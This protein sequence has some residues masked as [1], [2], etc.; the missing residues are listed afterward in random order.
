MKWD[1]LSGAIHTPELPT[2]SCQFR[3]ELSEIMSTLA[4]F[5]FPF[6]SCLLLYWFLLGNTHVQLF[7]TPWCSP[8]GSSVHEIL[9][10]RV[11][12]WVT[13]PFSRGSS[14]LSNRTWAFCIAGRFFTIW[15]ARAALLKR[16]PAHE[17]LLRAC[18]W[19]PQP[20]PPCD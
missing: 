16:S 5:P 18:F 13:I 19:G 9:Q 7:V 6:Q 15:A 11:R 2:G 10:T 12:E 8:P 20:K 1:L 14:G 17:S 4:L 3:G